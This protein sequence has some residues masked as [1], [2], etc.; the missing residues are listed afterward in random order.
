MKETTQSRESANQITFFLNG[1]LI[2]ETI[3]AGLSTLDWLTQ[4]KQMHGTKCSCN[5]G[6]CGAC[7]VVI[8]YPREGNVV[9]EAVTSCLYPAAKLHGRHLITV[10]GMGDPDKLH[11]IQQALLEHHG[12]QCGYCTPGFVM[13]MFALFATHKHPDKETIFSS[14]EGNLCRCTGYQSILDAA[15][16][17][18]AAYT[19]QEIVPDWCRAVEQELFAFN[20][21]ALMIL[22]PTGSP[23]LVQRYMVPE[24]FKSLFDIHA[25]EPDSEFIAGGTDL[26]VQMNISR[27]SFPILIDLTR[28]PQ[29]QRLYLQQDGLHIGSAVSYGQLL[30]SGIIKHDYPALHGLI[31]QI[32]SQQ[33]RNFGTLGGNIA[34]ASPIG[35]SLPMLLALDAILILQSDLEIRNVPIREF[36]VAYRQTALKKGEIIREIIL[37]MLPK[38]SFIR[39]HKSAKRKS[40][41]ISAVVSVIRVESDAGVIR[42][43]DLALGGVAATPKLS[44]KFSSLLCGKT[45]RELDAESIAKAVMEE[46]EP[47]SDVRGSAEYRSKLITTHI[48]SYLDE[49]KEVQS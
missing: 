23:R 19:P 15:Q 40:V 9:Y 44:A 7:T 16:D 27:K 34:N 21:P 46:F 22:K 14:L 2:I 25:V 32:A 42:K 8:A 28:I 13:G 5:E 12:T 49:L 10:E 20:K 26:M 11:P 24:D 37:P 1:R 48:L 3:P 47:L 38:H 31:S 43:A 6:D 33:I 17:I 30:D 4:S 18:A 41:D 29:L 36:F 35:D 45:A 39:F